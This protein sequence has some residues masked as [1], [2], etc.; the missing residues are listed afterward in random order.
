M[1]KIAAGMSL[2]P[3]LITALSFPKPASC[4]LQIMNCKKNIDWTR[5]IPVQRMVVVVGEAATDL[6]S[7]A[8]D[9]LVKYLRLLFDINISKEHGRNL[10]KGSVHQPAIILGTPQS[11]PLLVELLTRDSVPFDEET[12]G[13]DGY[14]IRAQPVKT[15]MSSSLAG[16][17]KMVC[18]MGYTNSYNCMASDST[19]LAM[20]CLITQTRF[21]F[22]SWISERSHTLE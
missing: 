4:E 3:I 22:Q 1:M 2:I 10:A 19:Q 11:N 16:A 20:S 12:P 8:S 9:E 14:I 6:E 7:Y 17:M 13:G 15:K 21:H 18:C 5:A